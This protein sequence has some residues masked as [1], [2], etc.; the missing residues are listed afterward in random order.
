[1]PRFGES[2]ERSALS[3]K[4]MSSGGAQGPHVEA[5]WWG[6][7]LRWPA[8]TAIGRIWRLATQWPTPLTPAI[9]EGRHRAPSIV[10]TG[11]VG[12]KT[13]KLDHSRQ[14]DRAIANASE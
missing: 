2:S 4:R 12:A 5:G 1:M 7:P 14:T 9:H 11:S 10:R 13:V 3:G 6:D 8:A